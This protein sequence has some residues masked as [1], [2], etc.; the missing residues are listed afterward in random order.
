M[1]GHRVAVAVCCM[2]AVSAATLS[3]WSRSRH[4]Q[5]RQQPMRRLLDLEAGN[6]TAE[7]PARQWAEPA[8]CS[9]FETVALSLPVTQPF[10]D[11][12]PL[13]F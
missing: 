9:D 1:E 5:G 7:R 4:A 13:P 11:E 12:N 3:A 8:S 6:F 2:L 10:W